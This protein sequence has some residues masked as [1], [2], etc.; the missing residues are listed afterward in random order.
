M[1]KD[2]LSDVSKEAA[3]KAEKSKCRLSRFVSFGMIGRG[4]GRLH[5][6]SNEFCWKTVEHVESGL[7]TRRE[8]RSDQRRM[9]GERMHEEGEKR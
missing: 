1:A 8:R 2:R 9:R 3:C 5:D 6:L 7:G 4:Y